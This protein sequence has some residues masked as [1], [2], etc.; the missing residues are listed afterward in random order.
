[1]S[2]QELQKTFFQDPRWAEVEDLIMKFV[3]P[4]IDMDTIDTSQPA[5]AVKAEVIGRLKAYTALTDFLKS[6]RVVSRP[7]R[8][9]KNN[10]D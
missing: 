7:L 9:L 3:D 5:E 2:L 10:W 1:M 4:L 8:E 6:T